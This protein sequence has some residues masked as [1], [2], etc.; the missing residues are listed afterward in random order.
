MWRSVLIAAVG[1]LVGCAHSPV[2]LSRPRAAP[3]ADFYEAIVARWVEGTG[4]KRIARYVPAELLTS[5][6]VAR[7]R[8]E[9]F[10]FEAAGEPTPARQS[11][12]TDDS[13]TWYALAIEKGRIAGERAFVRI[14]TTWKGGF[15]EE[16]YALIREHGRWIVARTKTLLVS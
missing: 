16:E 13:V 6:I 8:S 15:Q 10:V 14:L 2:A 3:T 9:G 4:E 12:D 5:P 11:W 1:L 7:L